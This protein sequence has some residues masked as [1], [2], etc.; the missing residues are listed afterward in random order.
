ME[1][2]LVVWW[3]FGRGKGPNLLGIIAFRSADF[4]GAVRWF[5]RALD[6]HTQLG[7]L[8]NMGGNRLNIG[9][10]YY[11]RGLFRRSVNELNAA[12]RLLE[13]VGARVSLCRCAIA[14]GNIIEAVN[15]GLDMSLE[16]GVK[17]EADLFAKLTETEDMREGVGAFL[18]KRRPKFQ[19]K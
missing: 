15:E 13:E 10:A 14:M 11:K 16:E 1:G 4:R 5:R 3:H 17:K 9:I 2:N 8:K 7:M 19:D 18:E 12:S 6:L